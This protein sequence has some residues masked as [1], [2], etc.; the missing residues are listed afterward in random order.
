VSLISTIGKDIDS[1][2]AINSDFVIP[3]THVNGAVNETLQVLFDRS[4]ELLLEDD[5]ALSTAQVS[6]QVRTADMTNIDRDSQFTIESELYFVLEIQE[7]VEDV[8][9]ITLSQDAAG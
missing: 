4:R 8:T 2:F 3:A 6:I 5:M 1:I 9:L 7:D